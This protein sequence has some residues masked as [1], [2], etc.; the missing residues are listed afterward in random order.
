M[1]ENINKKENDSMEKELE[2]VKESQK[3]IDKMVD[4]KIFIITPHKII[5]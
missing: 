4:I 5:S 1:R 2:L 3:I